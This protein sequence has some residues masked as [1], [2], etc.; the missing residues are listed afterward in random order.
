MADHNRKRRAGG[1]M[2]SGDASGSSVVSTSGPGT[3]GGPPWSAPPP[4]AADN[5]EDAD[6]HETRLQ[7]LEAMVDRM[8]R[9]MGVLRLEYEKMAVTQDRMAGQV[10]EIAGWTAWM[11]RV[12]DWIWLFPWR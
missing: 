9:S 2:G 8:C 6:V 1:A 7:A 12:Y 5:E 3:G 10:D 4:A 11:A